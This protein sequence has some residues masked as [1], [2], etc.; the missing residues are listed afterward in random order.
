[1]T[2]GEQIKSILYGWRSNAL[3]FASGLSYFNVTAATV[4]LIYRYGFILSPEDMQDVYTNVDVIFLLFAV[5]YLIR[6]TFAIHWG[7]FLKRS[8]FELLLVVFIL[9][10]G[11]ANKLFDF[12]PVL[13]YMEQW[14]V[15]NAEK[16][17]HDV[18]SLYLVMV[19]GLELTK[20]STKI[21]ELDFKP[22][23]TF[24][25]SFIVLIGIGT[26]LLMLP[27]MTYGDGASVGY[28]DSMPFIDALFT[29]A[30]ASCVTGLAVVDTGTYFTLKGQLVIMFLIQLGGI[31]IVSFATF[32]A[33]FL[34]KG[35]GIKH[36]SIIQDFLSSESLISAKTLLRKILLITFLVEVAGAGFIYFSWDD[37]LVFRSIGQKIFYSIFHSVSA[38]CNAGFC[39]FPQ[40]LFTNELASE[41]TLPSGVAIFSGGDANVRSMQGLHFIIA[42]LIILG[43]IGFGTIEDL[44]TPSKIKDRLKHP[45]KPLKISTRIAIGSSISL[46][47][48]G[49]V[50]FMVL[51]AHQL[52]SLNI[53]EALNTSF[54]QSVTCR[55]A[56]FN[57]MNFAEPTPPGTLLEPDQV[58]GLQYPT[59]I[60]CIFLMF[61]GAAPGSTGGGIKSSTFWLIARSSFAN[62]RGQERIEIGKRTIPNDL[63][64]KAYSIFM[65]ATTYNIIAIFLLTITEAGNPEISIL[66]IVFEQ[67]SAFATAGLSLGITGQLSFMGKIVII[68]SMYI[69]R[70]GT[71]TLALALSNKVKTNSYRYPEGHVMV[72]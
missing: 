45:W 70:V 42:L 65:F 26:G 25:F 46:I 57:T 44:L 30:S 54:F 56:G 51:E 60:L 24:I 15:E 12:K 16:N 9:A 20:I 22:A 68:I 48:L 6:F 3:G 2:I 39:L 67:I 13:Y 47:V 55:T 34:A 29:S 7:D 21:S 53:L 17:Y 71:L 19:L 38:F 50:G 43:G 64:H 32:F 37:N 59:I 27:A 11:V 41:L 66:E 33:T 8:W 40:G 58:I 18:L 28:R 62:I 10:N 72:G 4:L 61:I 69:G 35:V 52:R 14:A 63:I 5:I 49:T 31:G 36:Q 1:M 23:S